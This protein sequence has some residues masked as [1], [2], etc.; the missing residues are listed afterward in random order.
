MC[1][2]CRGDLDALRRQARL[3]REEGLAAVMVAPLLAG[4]ANVQALGRE[5]PDLA[6]LAHPTMGGAARIAPEVL[7]GQMF[8]LVGADAVIFPNYGGRF[9]YSEA[10]CRAIAEAAR[11]AGALPV[12]AGGMTLARVPE[13]LGFYGADV[14][15]LIG[16]NL[17]LARDDLAA[18]AR[19]FADAV[20]DFP[21][22]TNQPQG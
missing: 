4:L 10:R 5:F 18:A 13:L 1:R 19:R 15:L 11:E 2:A 17:L 6:L 7:I 16:G 9:G 12:P 8:P 20:R 3:A 14:M 21:F 22:T